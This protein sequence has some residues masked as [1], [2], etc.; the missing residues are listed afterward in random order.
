VKKL[1]R[2]FQLDVD[3]DA[4]TDEDVSADEELLGDECTAGRCKVGM[5]KAG[6]GTTEVTR[7]EILFATRL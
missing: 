3:D 7:R 2:N 5:C 1:T 6:S 4:C